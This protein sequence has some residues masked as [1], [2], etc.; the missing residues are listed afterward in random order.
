MTIF[1]KDFRRFSFPGFGQ[2]GTCFLRA[3]VNQDGTSVFLC[4]QLV[5]YQGTSV[6]NAVEDIFL[7]AVQ[8]LYEARVYK[9]QRKHWYSL[10]GQFSYKHIVANSRWVE[11]YPKGTGISDRDSY[12]LVSFDSRMRPIW[13]YVSLGRAAQEC[14]V[15]E[16][17]FAI[18]PE[19]IKYA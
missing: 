16:D 15:T 14:G 4:A 5:N 1:Q 8:M 13:N 7:K 11:H 19:D 2:E 17:F 12:A 10:G 18:S 9:I 3:R 6:T